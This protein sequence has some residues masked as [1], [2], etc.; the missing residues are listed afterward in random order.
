MDFIYKNPDEIKKWYLLSES[1]LVEH[2]LAPLQNH[3]VH[4]VPPVSSRAQPLVV[5]VS[6][7]RQLGFNAIPVLVWA[8]PL[9]Y[10]WRPITIVVLKRMRVLNWTAMVD[11]FV[12]L[13]VSKSVWSF[14]SIKVSL[15]LVWYVPLVFKQFTNLKVLM[16]FV[17]VE[18]PLSFSSTLTVSEIFTITR[19][20]CL[21]WSIRGRYNSIS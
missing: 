1:I 14:Y 15:V 17:G 4:L 16:C 18:R 13:L 8:S 20:A 10:R 9:T 6:H 5:E 11:W 21:D 19:D 12:A 2:H 7:I 3:I